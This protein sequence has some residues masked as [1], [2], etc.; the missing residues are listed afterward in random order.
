MRRT[1]SILLCVALLICMM[2]SV[3]AEG[4]KVITVATWD[5][6][7]TAY[8]TVTKDAFEASHPGVK[9]E[10]IDLASQDY[11]QKV[12]TMLAGGDSVD[13][14]HVKELSDAAN[15]SE[16]GY[17]LGLDDKI[18]ETGYDLSHYAG[19]S[20]CYID[21]EGKQVALPYRA[22]YWVLFYN[23]ALFD[24]AGLEYPTNDLTWDQYAELAEKITS[25]TEGQDKVYGTHYHTWLSAV[26][27]W[28]VCDGVNTLADGEYSDLA[29]FY[30]LVLDL[31]DK[32]AAMSF[33]DLKAS[34]LHYKGAFEAGNVAMLPMGYWFVAQLI[35]DKA[36]GVFD[37]DFGFVSVPHLEG[38]AAG[39]SFGSPTGASINAA[40]DD[41]DLA[42]EYISWL[43]SEEGA[44]A[45]AS[46][47]ARPAFIN[48]AVA[49]VMAGADGFPSDEA[50][51]AALQPVAVSLEWP[52][53]E[54]VSA[55][56]TIVNEEHTNIMTREYTVDEGIA[57]MNERV[58]EVL[59]D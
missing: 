15:W 52:T 12:S 51:K 54:K 57:A 47:G 56:K 38:V 33:P 35:A 44:K 45:F 2:P 29:Y 17:I 21:N 42:W 9:I 23:K 55:I 19:M 6:T 58:A 26:A 11:N 43:C 37:F 14:V 10:Y 28:A 18:A 8:L 24:A 16:Q 41:P 46:C 40:S 59:A 36:S 13:V 25:G 39:S 4:E 3:F 27:N 1:W 20:E 22:D 5:V 31:E 30:N 53:G 50:S 49:E 48:D 32:G 34:G 7:T